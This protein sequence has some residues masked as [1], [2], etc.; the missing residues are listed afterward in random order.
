MGDVMVVL[1]VIFLGLYLRAG[2]RRA[3]A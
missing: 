1:V 3:D 2:L